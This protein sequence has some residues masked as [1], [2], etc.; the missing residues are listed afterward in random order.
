MRVW[1]TR[2]RLLGVAAL[3][4]AGLLA[5]KGRALF[6]AALTEDFPGQ[7]L[8]APEAFAGADAGTITLIDIR[9]PAEW[10]ASGSPAPAMRLDMTRDDF[11]DALAHLVNGRRDA[12]IALI[13]ARGVRSARLGNRL[14]L[15]GFTNVMDVPEGMFGARAGPG[16][17]ARGLPLN[18]G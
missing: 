10:A 11:T 6:H 3:V 7:T 15:E 16:W 18:R 2:R 12:A 9:R 17:I 14:R 13:C 4:G 1:I 8:S 5:P